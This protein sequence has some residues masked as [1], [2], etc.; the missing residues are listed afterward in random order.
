M[1][2]YL[3]L[4][5][6]LYL[7]GALLH[8]FDFFDQRLVFS[9]MDSIFKTWIVYLLIGDSV[10]AIGLW[11]L[12]KFGEITFLIIAASQLIAYGFFKSIFGNQIL[13]IVFHVVTISI[14]LF[15]KTRAGG[16]PGLI[17]KRVSKT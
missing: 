6:I 17:D 3:R 5:S 15:L 2:F 11:R 13:L 16:E 10:A 1:K 9:E 8:V 14:Y 4:L 12:K 7:I